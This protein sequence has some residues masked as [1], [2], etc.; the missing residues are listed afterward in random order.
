MGLLHKLKHDADSLRTMRVVFR[1]MMMMSLD[2]D[3]LGHEA[4]D[5]GFAGHEMVSSGHEDGA[6]EL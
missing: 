2:H 1:T 3:V 4:Y 6:S 5:K